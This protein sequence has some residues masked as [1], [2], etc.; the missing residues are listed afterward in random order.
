MQLANLAIEGNDTCQS[1]KI[2]RV[3]FPLRFAMNLSG[4]YFALFAT[5]P[6]GCAKTISTAPYPLCPQGEQAHNYLNLVTNL[7]TGV[8]HG[9]DLLS[10]TVPTLTPSMR[11]SSRPATV[12]TLR[13][14]I[15]WCCPIVAVHSNDGASI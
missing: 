7:P 2:N 14:T 11:A 3:I 15:I 6:D 8:G 13:H 12:Q 9:G 4:A 1:T 5:A 10:S